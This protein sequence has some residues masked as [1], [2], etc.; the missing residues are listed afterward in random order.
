MTTPYTVSVEQ[1]TGP[2]DLLLALVAD[3]K[4]AITELSLSRVTEQFVVYVE[5]LE[6]DAISPEELADFLVVAAKLLLLKSTSWLISASAVI[7]IELEFL[8]IKNFDQ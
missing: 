4:M 8:N 2:L 5:S 3:Q 6:E 7:N 1:F